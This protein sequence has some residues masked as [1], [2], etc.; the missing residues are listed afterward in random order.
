MGQIQ[1]IDLV[2]NSRVFQKN[3]KQYLQLCDDNIEWITMKGMPNG[4]TYVGKSAGL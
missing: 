3:D 4:G 2:K 1:N